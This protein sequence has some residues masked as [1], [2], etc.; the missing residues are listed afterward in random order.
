M[1]ISWP[2]WSVRHP[3][4]DR[5]GHEW[6][7]DFQNPERERL[8]G[9]RRAPGRAPDTESRNGSCHFSPG[10]MRPGS[11]RAP[12][13]NSRMRRGC[14]WEFAFIYYNNRFFRGTRNEY[15]LTRMTRCIREAGLVTGDEVRMHRRA[16]GDYSISYKRRDEQKASVNEAGETVIR[17][18]VGW[19]VID[20]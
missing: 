10:S 17:L 5:N 8:G 6:T 3:L 13:C 18:G 16:S 2:R 1:G 11:I 14:F 19:K 4:Q 20:I 15:R 9:D 7:D 12:I